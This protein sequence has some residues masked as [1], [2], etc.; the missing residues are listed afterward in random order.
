M[1]TV[2]KY[3]YRLWVTRAIREDV[4]FID[5]YLREQ[6]MTKAAAAGM[7]PMPDTVSVEWHDRNTDPMAMLG[8]DDDDP[9]KVA[10]DRGDLFMAL[11]TVRG[12][13]R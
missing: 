4:Q 11:C 3:G 1:A 5:H 6:V 13:R 8:L 10:W 12:P 2:E 7:E 9:R